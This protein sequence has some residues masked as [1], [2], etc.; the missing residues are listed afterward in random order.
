MA[1]SMNVQC[2]C[3]C[4]ILAA[5]LKFEAVIIKA[6]PLLRHLTGFGAVMYLLE[7]EPK[8]GRGQKE[9]GASFTVSSSLVPPLPST[10]FSLNNL[11]IHID[12]VMHPNISSGHFASEHLYP[13]HFVAR[14][15][16]AVHFAAGHFAAGRFAA[17][18]GQF[19][20]GQFHVRSFYRCTIEINMGE[21]GYN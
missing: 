13:G 12:D 21:R 19:A 16:V 7:L 8:A 1:C 10:Y 20:A 9:C 5:L 18:A 15:S 14:H 17:G 6:F 2:K 11:H 3:C 4:T